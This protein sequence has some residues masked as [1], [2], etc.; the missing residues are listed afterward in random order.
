MFLQKNVHFKDF[1][2]YLFVI[3]RRIFLNSV[4]IH[5]YYSYVIYK[6]FLQ[7]L[8][9]GTINLTSLEDLLGKSKL[10]ISQLYFRCLI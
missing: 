10:N 1:F 6:T 2:K 9:T 3:Y 5:K 4:I 7:Y 8:Y